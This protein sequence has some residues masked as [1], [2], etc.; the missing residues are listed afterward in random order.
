ML[1]LLPF[2]K[3]RIKKKRLYVDWVEKTSELFI[4]QKHKIQQMYVMS[5]T[6]E[7]ATLVIPSC[8]LNVR[9]KGKYK[10]KRSIFQMCYY[11]LLYPI[12]LSYTQDLCENYSFNL[13]C[14]GY[15]SKIKCVA[16]NWSNGPICLE[17]ETRTWQSVILHLMVIQGQISSDDVEILPLCIYCQFAVS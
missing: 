1:L 8:E 10:W 4:G 11:S 17:N 5:M 7:H 15:F 13:K 9:T 2:R 12:F 14:L 6:A 3:I 16:Q